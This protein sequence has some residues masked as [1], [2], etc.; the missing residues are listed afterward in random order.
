MNLAPR[1]YLFPDDIFII[2]MC[3]QPARRLT[4]AILIDKSISVPK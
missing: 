4:G 2:V 3:T 1:R